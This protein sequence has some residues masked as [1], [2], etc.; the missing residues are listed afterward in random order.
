[1]LP[2]AGNTRL[3]HDRRWHLF[4]ETPDVSILR[5]L[6]DGQL[7][8]QCNISPVASA[9]PGRSTPRDEFVRDV[10]R[11]LGDRLNQVQKIETIPAA[12]STGGT[13]RVT[14]SGVDH[15]LAMTWFYYLC[16]APTGQQ[17]SLVFAVEQRLLKTWGSR[18]RDIVSTLVFP[19]RP[20][21]TA[22]K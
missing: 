8:A 10:R 1:M 6:E 4:H 22:G 7:V 9:A 21:R 15:G 17:V 13:L 19:K 5:R 14:A 16:T 11:T 2:A 3:F 12:N 18:D 20:P